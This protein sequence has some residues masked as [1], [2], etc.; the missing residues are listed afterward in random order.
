M[1][2]AISTCIQLKPPPCEHESLVN[3]TKGEDEER[4]SEDCTNS[5]LK[6]TGYCKYLKHAKL[7]LF[8]EIKKESCLST[9]HIIFHTV[10]TLVHGIQ[11]IFR[12]GET[13]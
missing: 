7:H 2:I 9:V 3:A 8:N 4:A 10:T 5:I 12:F 1:A 6:S 13:M 11:T